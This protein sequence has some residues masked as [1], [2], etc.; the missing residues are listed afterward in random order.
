M[1]P[2]I[3]LIS[4]CISLIYFNMKAQS[5]DIILEAFATGYTNIT[6]ISNAGD[7]R[8]FVVE[9][10]G[11]IR[12]LDEEGNFHN[13]PFLDITGRVRD[14]GNEQGL[15]GLTFHPDYASNGYF[16]V[17]YT[18]QPEGETH[19]SRFTMVSGN[20]DMAD[21]ASELIIFSQDQPFDNHN[22]GDLNFGPDGYLYFGLGDGGAAN[23]ELEAA[24]DGTTYLGKMIRIDVDGGDPYAIPADNP[25]VNDTSVLDEIWAL[26]VRNPWRFSFDRLNGDM[27]IADVGQNQYEEINV[28]SSNSEGGKNWGWD[29]YEGYELFE[30]AGCGPEDNYDFPVFVYAHGNTHCSVT[31]GYIYRGSTHPD[32]QGHYILTDLCSRNFWTVYETSAGEFDTTDQGQLTDMPVTTFGEDQDGELYAAERSGTIYRITTD[33]TTS[34]SLPNTSTPSMKVHPNPLTD[35]SILYYHNPSSGA[36]QLSL[37]SSN[38][39]VIWEFSDQN[40]DIGDSQLELGQNLKL[41]SIPSGIY[42]LTLKTRSNTITEKV[43]IRK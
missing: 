18:S 41:G 17:N 19:I 11:I 37:V 1:R 30:S 38:G 12:I 9:Q 31:G 28:E 33:S 26:G 21:P 34:T 42:Y 24:Q 5:P 22:A 29:C 23:D 6:D 15:L 25:F 13:E 7:E 4:L 14:E 32:L 8:L 35:S 40:A 39:N 27:W 16:Y 2:K 20:P 3:L 10:S 43:F 36:V